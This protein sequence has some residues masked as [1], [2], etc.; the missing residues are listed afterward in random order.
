M[1]GFFV[2]AWDFRWIFMPDV[3]IELH[4][5]VIRYSVIILSETSLSFFE[6]KAAST[7]LGGPSSLVY[8]NNVQ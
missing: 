5:Y 8:R 1:L 2:E 7:S 3:V 4:L 6:R